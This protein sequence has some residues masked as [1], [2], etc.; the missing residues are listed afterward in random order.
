[1][2]EQELQYFTDYNKILANY[3]RDIGVD[4]DFDGL[5]LTE[6]MEPPKSHMVYVS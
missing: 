5:D 4:G 2:T 1:M 6:H 3:M